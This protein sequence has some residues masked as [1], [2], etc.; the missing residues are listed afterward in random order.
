MSSKLFPNTMLL[1]HHNRSGTWNISMKANTKGKT[2]SHIHLFNFK[3][4]QQHTL[5]VYASLAAMFWFGFE[6]SYSF[7]NMMESDDR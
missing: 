6:N 1:C 3:I 4:W 2:V 5:H 7:L